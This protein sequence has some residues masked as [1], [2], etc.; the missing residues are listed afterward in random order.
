[1]CFSFGDESG[2]GIL[3]FLL[4]LKFFLREEYPR[5]VCGVRG[6]FGLPFALLFLFLPLIGDDTLSRLLLLEAVVEDFSL[7]I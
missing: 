7:R 5:G 3:L 1:M 6:V 2:E 4:K